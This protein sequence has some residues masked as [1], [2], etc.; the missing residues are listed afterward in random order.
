MRVTSEFWVG[1]LLRRASQQGAFATIIHKGAA[2][3]GAIFIIVNDLSGHVS[4]L[5]PAPQMSYGSG[6]SVDRL[7]EQVAENLTDNEL[8]EKVAR[9]RSFDPDVWV[10]EIEDKQ[11]RSFIQADEN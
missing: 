5:G 10:I 4:L 8:A 11:G 7:F 3:A 1:A 9:E 2:E 6:R